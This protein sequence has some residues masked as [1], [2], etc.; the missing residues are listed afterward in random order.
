MCNI[1]VKSF[2]DWIIQELSGK[3]PGD[4]SKVREPNPNILRTAAN[5]RARDQFRYWFI[6]KKP[7]TCKHALYLIEAT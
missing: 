4:Y 7:S 6:E 1:G 5:D 3:I 2:S